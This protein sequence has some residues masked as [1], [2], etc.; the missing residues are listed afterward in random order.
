MKIGVVALFTV[1]M[2]AACTPVSRPAAQPPL[3][4]LTVVDDGSLVQ[5]EHIVVEK[6]TERSQPMLPQVS[7]A[8]ADLA[9]RLGV[10]PAQIEVV[11]V[12]AVVWPDGSLGCPQPGMLYPQVLQDG[13]RIRLAVAG[14]IYQYH[15]GERRAPFL[16]TN[17]SEPAP[18]GVEI[19]GN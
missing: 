17:P 13:M 8:I 1:F 5:E 9:G 2:L 6:P 3:P 7:E 16:C 4:T 14:V 15:S 11:R 10:A 18:P 12:E 19:G